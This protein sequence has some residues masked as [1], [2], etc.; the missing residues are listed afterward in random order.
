MSN[1]SIRWFQL[2]ASNPLKMSIQRGMNAD[3]AV[4]LQLLIIFHFPSTT[5]A[6]RVIAMATRA[7][8]AIKAITIILQITWTTI[9]TMPYPAYGQIKRNDQTIRWASM[10]D[11]KRWAQVTLSLRKFISKR[12]KRRAPK[13]WLFH[14]RRKLLN[15]KYYFRNSTYITKTSYTGRTHMLTTRHCWIV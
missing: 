7:D 4:S 10:K 5:D 6:V 12:I 3:S 1:Y 11:A 14:R 2:K 9:T 8:R 13:K 15:K